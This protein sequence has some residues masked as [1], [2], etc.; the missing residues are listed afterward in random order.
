MI[1]VCFSALSIPQFPPTD[2]PE[3]A[4]QSQPVPLTKMLIKAMFDHALYTVAPD[5]SRAGVKLE[6]TLPG[7]SATSSK[8]NSLPAS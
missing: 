2:K 6:N 7:H 3:E 5:S 1:K 4:E 8:G